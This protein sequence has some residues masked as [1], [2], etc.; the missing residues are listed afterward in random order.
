MTFKGRV[1]VICIDQSYNTGNKDFIY[2]DKYVAKDDRFKHLTWLEF[3]CRRPLLEK[4]ILCNDARNH[5]VESVSGL[6]KTP[7]GPI[8]VKASQ[9]G[10][11]SLGVRPSLI[12]PLS[13]SN[14]FWRSSRTSEVLLIPRLAR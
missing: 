8:I 5:G 3:M 11:I 10:R 1:K 2:N 14:G 13:A 12:L 7:L 4:E 6:L 9:N